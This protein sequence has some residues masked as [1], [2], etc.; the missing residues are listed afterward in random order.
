MNDK[1]QPPDVLYKKSV[2][3]N[4]S[5]LTGK[6]LCQSLFF[7]K[8]VGLNKTSQINNQ[9]KKSIPQKSHLRQRNHKIVGTI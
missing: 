7:N 3:K 5:K 1:R 9:Y 8:V 4:F 2:L 6:H